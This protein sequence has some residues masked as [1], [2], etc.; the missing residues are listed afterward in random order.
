MKTAASHQ[1]R[2]VVRLP[3]GLLGFEHVKNYVL[4]TNP[5]EEPFMWLQML[6]D[7]KHA[8][9]VVPPTMKCARLPT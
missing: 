3:F 9:L 4:L 5:R 2:D 6:E 8:F 1:L 7:A